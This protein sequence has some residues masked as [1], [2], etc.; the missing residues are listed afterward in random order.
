MVHLIQ[1]IMTTTTRNNLLDSGQSRTCLRRGRRSAQRPTLGALILALRVA[2]PHISWA[3]PL[4]EQRANVVLRFTI[5]REPGLPRVRTSRSMRR[6][7]AP[8]TD[9]Y[10]L[11]L[12]LLVSLAPNRSQITIV[13]TAL[14]S[15]M[16]ESPHKAGEEGD[17]H[18][19]GNNEPERH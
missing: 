8:Q 1:E 12:F 2:R 19:I 10:R 6:G 9:E 3:G 14:C 11:G 18:Q 4:P 5:E 17:N 7:S 15:E 16:P 13:F